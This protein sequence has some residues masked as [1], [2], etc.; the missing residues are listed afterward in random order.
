MFGFSSGAAL[1]LRA[2]ARG[3]PITR[4][5]L[6][7]T[8]PRAAGRRTPPSWP[9][10]IAGGHR[11]DAVEYFQ[12][13]VVGIPEPVVAQMRHAPFRPALEAMAHTLVYDATIVAY[14]SLWDRFAAQVRQSTLAIAGSASPPSMRDVAERLGRAL[15]QGR[16]LTLEGATHD[17][18]PASLGPVLLRFWR[19][20]TRGRSTTFT[21][22][23]TAPGLVIGDPQ[24][25]EPWATTSARTAGR[26][27]R[28]PGATLA[29]RDDPRTA[30]R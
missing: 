13:R 18:D 1:A 30:V 20:A 2:G 14:E 10:S 7:E 25:G 27:W 6:Y 24:G 16:S 23:G 22:V 5:A 9:R 26:R 21:R 4:L 28:A 3:L 11:G 15:P 17:I 29:S 12:R 8:P 19:G